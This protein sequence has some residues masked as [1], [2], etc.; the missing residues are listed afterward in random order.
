MMRRR[1]ERLNRMRLRLDKS[2]R[3]DIV[4]E[5]IPRTSPP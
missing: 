1:R 3:R 4:F 2:D 5:N